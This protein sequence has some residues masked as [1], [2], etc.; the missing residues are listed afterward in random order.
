MWNTNCGGYFEGTKEKLKAILL[1]NFYVL[2]KH[3]NLK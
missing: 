1:L 2:F 3:N